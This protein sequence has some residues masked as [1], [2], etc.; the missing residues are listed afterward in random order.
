MYS[1]SL[2]CIIK[3]KVELFY[4]HDFQLMDSIPFTTLEWCQIVRRKKKSFWLSLMTFWLLINEYKNPRHK[5][6][7]LVDLE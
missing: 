3:F 7:V 6:H 2:V 4:L 1:L 5:Y